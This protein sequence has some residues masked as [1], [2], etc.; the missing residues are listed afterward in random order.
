MRSLR[1][2]HRSPQ[3]AVTSDT[4][5]PHTPRIPPTQRH[6]SP[7]TWLALALFFLANPI[8]YLHAATDLPSADSVIQ[9]LVSK[10]KVLSA[11]T[12][13]NRYVYSRTTSTEELDDKGRVKSKKEKVYEVK[14]IGGMPH[15]RLVRI[16]DQE[17]SPAQIQRENEKEES[18]HRRIA[19]E[20]QTNR[21]EMVL[22]DD[23][24][25]RFVF[26]VIRR[27]RFNDRDALVLSFSPK[28]ENL[29]EKRIADR[30]INKLNG[31]IWVD[32]QDNELAKVDLQL[33]EEVS[34]WG[35]FL[36]SLKKLSMVMDRDRLPNGTWFNKNSTV[37]IQGRK[38]LS[39][40]N[41]RAR[42]YAYDIRPEKAKSQP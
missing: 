33:R 24:T 20:R 5:H 2:L 8:L 15:P 30:V 28:S 39:S 35:G 31:T 16:N 27:E 9:K 40:L 36:G 19:D 13:S 41:I 23:L 12:N 14:L 29:P 22:T 3:R 25:S 38:L 10:A 21:R 32:E 18:A 42:E 6:P 11:D 7:T 17:L 26:T 34:L 37:V 4:A 1:T